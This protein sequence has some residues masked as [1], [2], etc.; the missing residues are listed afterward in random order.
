[1]SSRGVSW[2][3]FTAGH[4]ETLVIIMCHV[5]LSETFTVVNP[6]LDNCEQ[7]LQFLDD[8]R[9]FEVRLASVSSL[10]GHFE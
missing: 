6:E 2:T 4:R 5:A 9:C 7:V 1:M 3:T 10:D 8:L